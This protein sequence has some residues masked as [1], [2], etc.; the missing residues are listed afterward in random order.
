MLDPYRCVGDERVELFAVELTGDRG[1]V[2]DGPDPAVGPRLGRSQCLRQLRFRPDLRRPDH[3]GVECGGHRPQVQVMVVEPG[4]HGT[5]VGVDDLLGV[6]RVESV[7]DVGDALLD[8]DVGDATVRQAGAANQHVAS[9]LSISSR[10]RWLSAPSRAA[11]ACGGIG[12]RTVS[13][14]FEPPPSGSVA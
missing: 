13:E 1:V 5:A 12:T 9:R 4:Q 6:A 3:E 11:G 14:L 10:T 7:G 8:A 2:P